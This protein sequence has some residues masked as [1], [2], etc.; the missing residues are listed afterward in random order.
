MLALPNNGIAANAVVVTAS[1]GPHHTRIDHL[2]AQT[3]TVSTIAGQA[4][5]A[6]KPS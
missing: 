2:P 4:S 5:N 3:T 1:H 6:G